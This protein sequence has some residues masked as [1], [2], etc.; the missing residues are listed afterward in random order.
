MA[1]LQILKSINQVA[2]PSDSVKIFL[3]NVSFIDLSVHNCVVSIQ[4]HASLDFLIDVINVK[5]KQRWA[6][7]RALGNS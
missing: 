4:T 2:A 7:D 6:K 1:H 3:E 5:Q